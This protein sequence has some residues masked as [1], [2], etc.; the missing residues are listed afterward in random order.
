M[1]ANKQFHL[2]N[3]GLIHI[4]NCMGKMHNTNSN[5]KKVNN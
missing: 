4:K 2:P 1:T 3:T 5:S